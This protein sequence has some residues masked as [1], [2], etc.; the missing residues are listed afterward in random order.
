QSD[1]LQIPE[2]KFHVPSFFILILDYKTLTIISSIHVWITVGLSYEYAP[3][4]LTDD[5]NHINEHDA[6]FYT[7]STKVKKIESY[8]Q[9]SD[10]FVLNVTIYGCQ[11]NCGWSFNLKIDNSTSKVTPVA[12]KQLPYTCVDDPSTSRVDLNTKVLSFGKIPNPL[13]LFPLTS[14]CIIVKIITT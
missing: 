10:G 13:I 9:T 5:V 11:S 4:I 2:D 1:I 12:S 7:N 6:H 14:L 3:I 8:S